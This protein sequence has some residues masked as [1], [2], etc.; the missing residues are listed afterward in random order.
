M[1]SFLLN[2]SNK[3]IIQWG[4][5]PDGVHFEGSV[6]PGYSKAVAPSGNIVILDVDLKGDKDGYSHIPMLIMAE[7]QETFNYKTKSGGGHFWLHYTGSKTLINRAT[8]L[9]LDLR[10]GA[11][12][13]NCGGYVKYHHTIDIRECEHLILNSSELMNK[14]LEKLFSNS[15]E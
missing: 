12:E 11:K 2:S 13:G 10:I 6:P 5:L 3:P 9:G 14:W 7:L 1:K 15:E 4:S 8:S